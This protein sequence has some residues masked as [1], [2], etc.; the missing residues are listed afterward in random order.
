[1]AEIDGKFYKERTLDQMILDHRKIAFP[2]DEAQIL[3]NSFCKTLDED[4]SKQLNFYQGKGEVVDTNGK[5]SQIY[6]I[7]NEIQS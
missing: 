7:S 4:V 2:S 6:C 3:N 5:N 1:M